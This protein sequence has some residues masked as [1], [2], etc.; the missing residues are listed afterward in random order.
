M[1]AKHGTCGDCRHFAALVQQC[2]AKSPTPAAIPS[3]RGELQVI[4]MWPATNK[5]EWCGDFTAERSF[6]E[7]LQAVN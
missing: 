6:A 5:N 1:S 3:G 7:S 4:G 2:R